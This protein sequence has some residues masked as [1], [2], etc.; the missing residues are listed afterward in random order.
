MFDMMTEVPSSAGLLVE[1]VEAKFRE[2][3]V[4]AHC[5]P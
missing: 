1:E 2:R 5:H 4:S 3:T